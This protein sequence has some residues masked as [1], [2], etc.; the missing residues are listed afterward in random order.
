M[1]DKQAKYITININLA[2]QI[3]AFLAI[4]TFSDSLL[5]IVAYILFAICFSASILGYGSW[6]DST[7]NK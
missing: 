1:T 4:A 7:D 3:P 2:I 5:G 6:K